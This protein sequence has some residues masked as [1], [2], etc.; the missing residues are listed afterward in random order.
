MKENDVTGDPVSSTWE[1][2]EKTFIR[3]SEVKYTS[4]REL[5]VSLIGDD[6]SDGE[7]EPKSE[8][9][10]EVD[11]RKREQLLKMRIPSSQWADSTS[12]NTNRACLTQDN[13][14]SDERTSDLPAGATLEQLPVTESVDLLDKTLASHRSID[15]PVAT[16]SIVDSD[17]TLKNGI[18]TIPELGSFKQ[19]TDFMAIAT[20]Q[21]IEKMLSESRNPCI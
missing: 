10:K 15:T 19:R 7:Q 18:V 12:Y 20:R 5:P 2:E 1:D 4:N 16:S 3:E 6:S 11:F 8:V 14:I 21:L 17:H 13:A 9:A